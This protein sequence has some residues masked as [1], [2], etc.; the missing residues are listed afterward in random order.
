MNLRSKTR[1][2]GSF[3]AIVTCGLITG[4]LQVILSTSYAA[5]IYNGDLSDFLGQGIGFSLTGALI[6]ATIIAIFATLPGTI[7]SNQDV[8]VAIFTIISASIVSKMPSGTTSEST[9]YTVIIAISLTVLLAGLF[10]LLLGAFHLGGLIRYFPYPVIGGFLAGAGWLLFKGGVTLTIE[11]CSFTEL[12]QPFYLFHW[13]PGLFFALTLLIMVKRY[14]NVFLFPLFLI[15]GLILFYG[16]AW[17]LGLS[18]DYLSVNGWLLGPFNKQVSWQPLT[19]SQF[20]LVDW[21]I[22]AK[23]AGNMTTVIIVGAI[24]LLLNA[25][26]FELEVK[27]DLDLDKELRLAGIA[28]LFSCLSPGFVGFRQLGLSVLNYRMQVQSRMVGLIG[29]AVIG[30]ALMFGTSAL[31][32]FPRVIMGG[33]IMYLGL[34][35]LYEWAYETFF[36]LPTIDFLIIW[37]VFIVIVT[38]GFMPGVGVG[39]LAAVIMFIISYS[40]SEVVRHELSGKNFQ[41]FE[42]RSQDQREVLDVHGEKLYIL[43][44]Q[45]FIFFGTA[46]R[47]FTRIKK[48][49]EE[50]TVQQSKFVVLDFQK[51]VILDSTGML[52]FRKL[53][54]LIVKNNNHLVITGASQKITRQLI[55][56]GLSTA[57]LHINYFEHLNDGMEWCENQI[58]HSCNEVE[59]RPLTLQQQLAFTLPDCGDITSLL[60]Y[61][62]RVEVAPGSAIISE[63]EPANDFF[64]IESGKVIATAKKPKECMLHLETMKNGRVVGDIS[65]Y[66]G[67]C[68]TA[69][70]IATDPCVMYRMS[71]EQIKQLEKENPKASALL[72]Q[73][74][75]RLLAE[76]VSHLVKTVNALHQ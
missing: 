11:E 70:V 16:N 71:L 5:L 41:S 2:L 43:Q 18:L 54:D 22:I 37:L 56:G 25:S 55:K 65:F 8:S 69:Q 44:L 15:L 1:S 45:G 34:T 68:R 73:I 46:Y 28:N 32:Y 21:S 7:G 40:R 60:Q 26:A 10:F 72:H 53:L 50:I 12:F 35:F 13:L 36:T 51:V 76:R 67:H 58:L 29:V 57:H 74:M 64:F 63:G 3:L 6:I 31:S 20:S 17:R 42:P 75:V 59:C 48:R 14:H 23:Q 33:L 66:L 47:L 24:A 52:S 61:M 62:E 27:Q 9:F 38:T 39:L 19:L 49:M 4:T 30:L